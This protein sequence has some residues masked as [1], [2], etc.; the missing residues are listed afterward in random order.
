MRISDWSSDV[1][2]SDLAMARVSAMS[3]VPAGRYAAAGSD[4]VAADPADVDAFSDMLDA[5]PDRCCGREVEVPPERRRHDG[6]GGREAA[7][8]EFQHGERK[9]AVPDFLHVAVDST[10]VTAAQPDRKTGVE[11]KKEARRGDHGG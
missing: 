5:A 9:P 10:A 2:S 3:D 7:V 6:E 11:G 4:D 8:L 1:C